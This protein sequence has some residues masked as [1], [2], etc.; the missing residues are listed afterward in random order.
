DSLLGWRDKKI[1]SRDDAR[2]QVRDVA[3]VAKEML[4]LN[5]AVIILEFACGACN[6]LDE[7]TAYLT[8]GQ[9]D[10]LQIALKSE[11]VGVGVKL[12]IVDRKLLIAEVLPNSPAA[13]KG[14]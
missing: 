3:R 11:F 5:P 14:L 1:V 13:L 6:A 2:A 12:Q 7:Y 9:V 10:D 8:P 4:D